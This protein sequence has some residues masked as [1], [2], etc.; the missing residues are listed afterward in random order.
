[1]ADQSTVD[2]PAIAA[3]GVEYVLVMGQM[4][5]DQAGL[6]K[7]VRPGQPIKSQLV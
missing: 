5:K 7:D 6:H 3:K 4:V 1:V 2:D